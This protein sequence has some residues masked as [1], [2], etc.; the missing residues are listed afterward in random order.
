M[1]SFGSND[2]LSLGREVD[3][4]EATPELVRHFDDF[5]PVRVAA[6]DCLALALDAEGQLRQWGMF[7]VG[8]LPWKS[9]WK[10]AYSF[11]S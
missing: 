1:W 3:D 8:Y 5:K 2:E 4:D 9:S 10:I 6:T 11:I 7:K